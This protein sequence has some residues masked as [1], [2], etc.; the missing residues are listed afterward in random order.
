MLVFGFFLRPLFFWMCLYLQGYI[1]VSQVPIL[2][3]H[4]AIGKKIY[5]VIFKIS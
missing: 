2:L 3:Y 1:V 5:M 4:K